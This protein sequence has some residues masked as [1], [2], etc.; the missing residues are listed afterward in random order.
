MQNEEGA[1]IALVS[2]Q[3][4]EIPVPIIS[5]S[6]D[7]FSIASFPSHSRFVR[8]AAGRMVN[9]HRH[10]S[11][12]S[13]N[14]YRTAEFLADIEADCDDDDQGHPTHRFKS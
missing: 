12:A 13:Q 10:E 9:W 11:E 14:R 6:S 2:T 4:H 3:R 8:G 5:L 7:G 1:G